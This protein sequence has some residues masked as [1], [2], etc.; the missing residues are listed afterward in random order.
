LLKKYLN[1]FSGLL[2]QTGTEEHELDQDPDRDDE[3]HD[4]DQDREDELRD[5]RDQEN[6]ERV[7]K[8]R[9][10]VRAPEAAAKVQSDKNCQSPKT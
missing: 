10:R 3:D 6:Q 1:I 4:R 9:N 8:V 7:L 5:V 2:N